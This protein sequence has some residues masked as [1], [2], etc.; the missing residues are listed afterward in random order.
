[1]TKRRAVQAGKK[2]LSGRTLSSQYGYDFT[3]NMTARANNYN[4]SN[5]LVLSET[6]TFSY[7]NCGRPLQTVHTLGS[8]NPV[9]LVDPNGR[10]VLPKGDKELQIIK[11]TLPEEA[12]DYVQISDDGYINKNALKLYGGIDNNFTRLLEL[13]ETNTVVT[14]S[15][16]DSFK[17]ASHSGAIGSA[18]LS[19]F[20]SD[21]F[22]KDVSISIV[23]G[24]TT[25]ES[26]NYGKT[27]FPDLVGYQNSTSQNIEI[28][29][30]PSLSKTGA[31]EAFSHE[32][33]GH[34][35][36]Y[37]RNGHNHEGASHQIEGMRD[38]N[39]ILVNMILD[40]RR[41][42]INNLQK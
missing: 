1:M 28:Y 7:D 13:V 8:C 11:N 17:Y 41:T 27:L 21:D 19:Y 15:S 16:Q 3:G 39:I 31:A 4:V 22:L 6:Y 30:H 40:A 14:V 9:N 32:G 34:A 26:G 2:Y 24:L 38:T 25:G 5:S 12:R 36:L 37:I 42:T 10:E 18:N 20:P 23:S 33:Y 35:L 29:I